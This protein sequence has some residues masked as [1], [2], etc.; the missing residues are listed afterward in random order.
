[1][2]ALVCE[3]WE[4]NRGIYLMAR[5]EIEGRRIGWLTVLERDNAYIN[6][7]RAMYKC[8]CECGNE[9]SYEKGKIIRGEFPACPQ[10]M[11]EPANKEMMETL[12]QEILNNFEDERRRL[13]NEQTATGKK[14]KSQTVVLSNEQQMFVDLALEGKNILVDAC[15]GSGKTTAIQYLCDALPE[16]KRILYLT[17]N[18]LLKIDA[19]KKIKNKNV[20]VNNYHGYA[21][22]VLK[23]KD[24]YVGTPD[25]IQEYIKQKP[26]IDGYDVLIL[27]EYQDL[28]TELADM[29]ELIKK[30]NPSMQ[31]IAVG[32]MQQKIYDK[33]TLDVYAFMNEFL[34]EYKQLEFTK[35]FR[36]S[37]ELA[38]KLG[39][40]WGKTIEGV[41]D[42]CIVEEMD[43]DEAVN[44]LSQQ[45]PKDI[46]CLGARRG[47]M[48]FVLNELESNYSEIFNK[49]TVY[50]SIADQDR[51]AVEPKKTSAIFTTYDSSKGLER[52]I[53]VIFDF[54]EKY[55]DD[56]LRIPLQKYE[57][58]RNIFCVAASRGKN[59]IIFIKDGGQRLSEKTLSTPK[60]IEKRNKP[61]AISEMF[62]FKYKENVEECYQLLEIEPK[63]VKDHRRI[64]VK[65]QDALIDLSPCIGNY[66]EAS[67]F[68]NYNVDTYI[69]FYLM[70]EAQHMRAE[71]ENTY[72]HASTEE[73]ILFLTSLETK[74]RRYRTQV[75]LP[76]ITEDEKKEIHERLAEVFV[77]TEEVQAECEIK[78]GISQGNREA[79]GYAD[80]V[81]DNTVYELKFVAELQHTHFL[82]C[83]CYMIGLHLDRGIL[84]NVKTND[85][86][87]IKVPDKD[88]FMQQVWKT[89]T[90]NYEEVYTSVKDGHIEEPNI[91]VI[92]TETNWN[93][94]VMSIGLVI[95]DSVTFAVR[96]KYYYILTPECSVGGMYSDVLRLVDEKSITIEQ[97][98]EK[99]LFSVKKV[100]RDNNIQRLFAYNASFDKKH[101]PELVE[102]EWYDIMRLAAYRKFNNIIPDDAECYKTGKLK[103]NYGVEPM[104]RLL[105]GNDTY[106]E[107]HNA[108][109]DAAD[110]LSIMQMLEQPLE[111]YN[112][113]RVR[114]KGD[115]RSVTGQCD[116]SMSTKQK[117][118]D[119][120]IKTEE[121]K[122]YTAQEVADLLGV[123]K[124]TVYNLIKREEIYAR[125]QGNRYAIRSTDVYEY[126]ERE[127]EKQSEK[128]ASY[129]ECVGLLFL[130][131]AF[132]LLGFILS[133]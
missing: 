47:N 120:G 37:A 96:E 43:I 17:Y 75:D 102:V 2:N 58:L 109:Q 73:K 21:Y 29:L 115:Q 129:W 19:R 111:E 108:I 106:C 118:E 112:I 38:A 33:T 78:S 79:R 125:K 74:Q 88:R 55:W 83:A 60:I 127:Q 131:G 25:L 53:C 51:G 10:C 97:T 26:D 7:H 32:D 30:S 110:E 64:E 104:I 42:N 123:S 94:D 71:Y 6:S 22:M 128:E 92:D 56:R 132:L 20:T 40:I 12:Q 89:V 31:I 9:R 35:C 50:A 36:L 15:I 3:K 14:K 72:R 126:L 44:F 1:M 95:A 16:S 77:P 34:G 24:I 52:P 105:S 54:T 103:K 49:K 23:K 101:L 66:Q 122:I 85:M 46:L 86:Y 98:R 93:D 59:H 62:D 41:N 5:I 61:M 113:A 124:S 68:G 117:Q 121:E 65:N 8:R 116:I 28:E 107:T 87:E 80:V 63:Q 84:W 133:K 4:S 45:Q 119:G 69:Q 13:P 70:W 91:A 130:I 39:R 48:A 82:Q 18:R 114:E 11:S 90:N 81:K 99:A 57:I 27:D 100:L 76:F 67:F